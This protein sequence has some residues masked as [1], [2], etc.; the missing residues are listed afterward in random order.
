MSAKA[1]RA[2]RQSA[3]SLCRTSPSTF[4]PGAAPLAPHRL[5]VDGSVRQKRVLNT[6][7]NARDP[8]VFEFHAHD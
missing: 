3:P 6:I 7:L 8:W 5:Y 1:A 4:E 2:G